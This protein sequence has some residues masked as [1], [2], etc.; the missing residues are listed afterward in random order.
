MEEGLAKGLY[1]APVVRRGLG[2]LSSTG[3]QMAAMCDLPPRLT[4]AGVRFGQ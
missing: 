2:F 3:G 1:F 4:N